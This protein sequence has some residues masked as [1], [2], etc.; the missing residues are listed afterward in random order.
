MAFPRSGGAGAEQART[1][2]VVVEEPIRVTKTQ[3]TPA[4]SRLNTEDTLSDLTKQIDKAVGRA[5][6]KLNKL[7][8][9]NNIGTQLFESFDIQRRDDD[10]VESELL[11]R[12]INELRKKN[13]QIQNKNKQH[14]PPMAEHREKYHTV[15]MNVMGM[16]TK[17]LI[18]MKIK[19]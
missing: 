13:I 6:A 7:K 9:N 5:E 2:P 19:A 16:V 15:P 1:K 14:H 11:F 8:Q 18:R 4:I 17:P 10:I 3:K 12:Q